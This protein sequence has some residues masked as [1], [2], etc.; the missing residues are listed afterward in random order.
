[1]SETGFDKTTLFKAHTPYIN[2]LIPRSNTGLYLPVL[3]KGAL[4]PQTDIVIPYMYF[5][6]PDEFAGRASLEL[7][8]FGT[9][10]SINNWV[11]SFRVK[12]LQES[13]LTP[14]LNNQEQFLG[15]INSLSILSFHFAP[16]S[17]KKNI[18][19]SEHKEKDFL[20]NAIFNIQRTLK[21]YDVILSDVEIFQ[22]KKPRISDQLNICFVGWSRGSLRGNFRLIGAS[23]NEYTPPL[24]DFQAYKHDM[25]ENIKN[26]LPSLIE[27]Y[28]IFV[29]FV[30]ETDTAS[31]LNRQDLK[32][33]AIETLDWTLGQTLPF[34]PVNS[35]ITVLAD[36]PTNLGSPSS[37]MAPTPFL[38]VERGDVVNISNDNFCESAIMQGWDGNVIDMMTLRKKIYGS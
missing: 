26:K 12:L 32:I 14:D 9:P 24:F 28:D 33:K 16:Y 25:Q 35:V 21:N 19:V 27:R 13:R 1:M 11:A 2:K 8:D 22:Y 6:E 10:P 31:H 29:F 34:I 23:I 18:L 38:M 20:E 17:A 15:W 4:N 30:K 7:L 3:Q 36:H 37:N 5:V